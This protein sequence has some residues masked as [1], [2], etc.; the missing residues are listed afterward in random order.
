MKKLVFIILLVLGCVSLS[1]QIKLKY[2]VDFESVFNNGEYARSSYKKSSTIFGARVSPWIGFSYQKDKDTHI[3]MAG[4]DL[5]REFADEIQGKR[6]LYDINIYYNYSHQFNNTKFNLYAGVIPK[7]LS[8]NNW[9]TAFFSDRYNF[10]NPSMTGLMLSWERKTAHF[11]L[12]CDWI[13]KKSETEREQFMVLSLGEA[14]P[15]KWLALGYNAYM[16]HYASSHTVYGV[17]DN[18]LIKPYVKF[19]LAKVLPFQSF[20]LNLA[21]MQ[22]LQR[23]RNVDKS[24]KTPYMASFTT[25][26]QKWGVGLN[27]QVYFGKNIMP[28]YFE[29]DYALNQYGS[30]FYTGDPFFYADF[31]DR[32][33]LYYAPRICNGV[34]IKASWIWHFHST[35]LS[36][37]Q[38]IV[39]IIL[40]LDEL[41]NS[42]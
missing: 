40:N 35:G 39:G 28:L 24:F 26:I 38:Q 10:Y 13:G 19:D 11:E 30:N 16:M 42:R 37:S 7:R 20:E 23:D 22:S 12:S 6:Y 9:G 27:N 3:L 17:C 29:S 2:D 4:F 1:A 21:W 31:Y 33:E 32:L 8:Y 25:N 14:Y 18:F 34:N 36:G 41:I 15:I 5:T